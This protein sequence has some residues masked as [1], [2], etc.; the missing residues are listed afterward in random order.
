MQIMKQKQ[1]DDPEATAD[2]IIS[3]CR[4]ALYIFM[5]LGLAGIIYT[6][7]FF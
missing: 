7:I 3:I 2:R 4:H 1:G 6:L 5:L